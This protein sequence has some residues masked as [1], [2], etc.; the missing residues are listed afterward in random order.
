MSRVTRR[1]AAAANQDIKQEPS[2][3]PPEDEDTKDSVNKESYQRAEVKG[4]PVSEVRK[5]VADLKEPGL[6]RIEVAFYVI[7]IV[8]IMFKANVLAVYRKSNDHVS[9]FGPY[10]LKPGW[11]ILGGKLQDVS[12][13]EWNYSKS[14]HLSLPFL[15][16]LFGHIILGRII[17]A[18]APKLKSQL[19][20]AY[21]LACIVGF[22][23]WKV[24]LVFLLHTAVTFL[25]SRTERSSIVW[26]VMIFQIATLNF[27]PFMSYQRLLFEEEQDFH[28]VIFGVAM[29]QLRL[30]SFGIDYCQNGRQKTN[31]EDR[32][33]KEDKTDKE[34][35]ADKEDKTDN[36]NEGIAYRWSFYHIIVYNFGSHYLLVDLC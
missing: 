3:S 1:Q 2:S 13:F 32:T 17:D 36:G 22:V 28:N 31:K 34:D 23:G 14:T 7:C 8:V 27:D 12:D 29:C 20:L 5:N 35:M 25:A 10:N 24:F 15:V 30:L 18:Y 11:R 26:V 33:D 21:S 6:P 19:S 4:H 9:D 16:A